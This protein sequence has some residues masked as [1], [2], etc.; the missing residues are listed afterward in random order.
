M[1]LEDVT[2][3]Q[4]LAAGST[5][6]ERSALIQRIVCDELS[7]DLRNIVRQAKSPADSIEVLI[8]T[9]VV[10]GVPA[11]SKIVAYRVHPASLQP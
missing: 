9:H 3:S 1:A 2:S 11:D 10:A 6:D 5:D 7:P 4:P 8:E